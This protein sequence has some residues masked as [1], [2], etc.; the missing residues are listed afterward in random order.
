MPSAMANPSMTNCSAEDKPSICSICP[1]WVRNS[2]APATAIMLPMPPDMAVPPDPVAMT[3]A[4]HGLQDDVLSLLRRESP[5][6]DDE[7]LPLVGRLPRRPRPRGTDV[8]R[9][10]V[11]DDVRRSRQAVLAQLPLGE[12]RRAQDGVRAIEESRDP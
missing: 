6:R 1:S 8:G 2:A 9:N 3:C 7:E 10:A 4:A 5:D 11:G 12:G